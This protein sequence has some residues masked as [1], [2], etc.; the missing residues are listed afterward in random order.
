MKRRELLKGLGMTA[1]AL[2][3]TPASRAAAQESRRTSTEEKFATPVRA[4]VRR[5][6]VLLQPIT[7]TLPGEQAAAATLRIDDQ[8][9]Q[10]DRISRDGS[11]NGDTFELFVPAVSAPRQIVLSV[12]ANGT[13]R[14]QNVIV[15]PVRE[16]LTYILPMSH[17][18]L[19]Y[20]DLQANVEDK[21]ARNVALGM[22]LARMTAAYPEGSRFIWNLEA[23]WGVDL[24][25]QRR[26]EAERAE[27][28]EAI[29][30]G[31]V[32]LSGSYANELTGLCRSEE[33]LE[34]FRF[35]TQLGQEAGIRV[36]SAMMS[37]VPGFTWGTVTAMAQAGI[38]YFSAAPNYFDR[39]GTFM[40]EWQDKPFWWVS[41]CGQEKVL[42]WVP[43]TGY[44]MS[45]L[46]QPGP[47]WVTR[48]QDRLDEVGYP[49]DIS[50]IRWSGHGDNAYPDPEICEFARAWNETYEWPR[51]AIAWT[52]TA[53]AAM[54][55]KYGSQLP[56]FRGDLTPYW[57]DGAGSSALE[58]G[59][60][61]NAADRLTQAEALLAMKSPA[62][63]DASAFRAAWRDVLM[64]SEHTWG[65][66]C[67]VSDSEIPFTKDQ[68]AFREIRSDPLFRRTIKP[69]PLSGTDPPDRRHV[70]A[71]PSFQQAGV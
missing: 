51:F 71:V 61:R 26:S 8:V 38:R 20:T 68:W 28:I 2:L 6:G 41:P 48:Y 59:I 30:R 44:A 57:E 9:V 22:E 58:T 31:Q 69:V 3:Y 47:D 67:S 63:Y 11:M 60:S 46:N 56:T 23:L 43:W 55:K 32:A 64:Y 5:R 50:H 19:G 34:L 53:F 18:D 45:H 54:E 36:D 29:R 16:V 40:V 25:L 24:F 15:K 1:G 52:S 42:V 66:W 4:L 65:A 14:S 13:T 35:G 27:L 70:P 7:L 62:S 17:H 37:D 12:E 39:I 49:Y 33:L 10:S 21:Q